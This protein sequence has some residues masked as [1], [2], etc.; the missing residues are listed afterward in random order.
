M[1]YGIPGV[2]NSRV[3]IMFG[4]KLIV[5]NVHNLAVT[6]FHTGGNNVRP[7]PTMKLLPSSPIGKAQ[8]VQT[9]LHP[10]CFAALHSINHDTTRPISVVV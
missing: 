2:I 7:L 1:K 4:E 8:F 3:C 5:Q 10:T 9:G 6:F